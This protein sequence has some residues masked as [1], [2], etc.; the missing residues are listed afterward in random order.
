MN[1]HTTTRMSSHPVICKGQHKHAFVKNE[2]GK[3]DEAKI[4][5][6]TIIFALM[7][8]QQTNKQTNDKT[9]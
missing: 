6:S 4:A 2:R 1:K 7:L 5:P 3:E 9:N 8:T